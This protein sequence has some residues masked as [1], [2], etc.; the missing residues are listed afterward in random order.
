VIFI[1]T[2]HRGAVLASSWIGRWGRRLVKAPG[3]LADVRDSA[4]AVV[5]DDAAVKQLNRVPNSID[6]LS[7]KNRFVQL[8]N[9]LPLAAAVSYHSI[10]G[11]RAGV[12]RPI[13]A[14]ALSPIGVRIWMARDLN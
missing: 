1:S 11:D 14:T 10:I 5:T 13:A 12:T 4:V 3:F 2:P 7:P 9:N 8:V 6:T